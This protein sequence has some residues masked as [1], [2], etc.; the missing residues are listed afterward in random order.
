GRLHGQVR[1][2]PT[3][4]GQT[5][6]IRRRLTVP[7]GDQ[8]QRSDDTGGELRRPKSAPGQINT[9]P[10]GPHDVDDH[11]PKD[12]AIEP[13]KGNPHTLVDK[14]AVHRLRSPACSPAPRDSQILPR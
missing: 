4:L 3:T 8:E 14:R 7:A 11:T 6:R 9:S 13:G 10:S 1:F 2:D 5:G 12:R